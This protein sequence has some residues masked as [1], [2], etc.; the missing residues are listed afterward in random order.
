MKNINYKLFIILVLLFLY[1]ER[2]AFS[3]TR[4][5][6]NNVKEVRFLHK[7]LDS[8]I[9]YDQSLFPHKNLIDTLSKTALSIGDHHLLMQSLYYKACIS[10]DNNVK[11]VLLD[12]AMKMAKRNHES[13]WENRIA[14]SVSGVLRK[15]G[16]LLKAYQSAQ[17][18]E[19]FFRKEDMDFYQAIAFVQIGSVLNEIQD[20]KSAQSYFEKASALFQSCGNKVCETKNRLNIAV[21]LFRNGEK[22]KAYRTM[23]DLSQSSVCTAD[24]LFYLNVLV[25]IFKASDF[26][27]KWSMDSAMNICKRT[28]YPEAKILVLCC[29]GNAF[30]ERNSIDSAHMFYMEALEVTRKKNINASYT[31]P[32][33]LAL[34][35]I[36]NRKSLSDSAYEYLKRYNTIKESTLDQRKITHYQKEEMRK[37]ILQ[38]QKETDF[39][40]KKSKT[41]ITVILFFSSMVAVSGIYSYRLWQS[42]NK[43]NIKIKEELENKNRQLTTNSLLSAE[44]NNALRNIIERAEEMT[45]NQPIRIQTSKLMQDLKKMVHSGKEWDFFK[46]HFE[47]VHPNF[48]SLLKKRYPLLSENEL[49]I[50]ALIRIGLTNKEI[51]KMLNITSNTVFTFRYRI[52]KKFNDIGTRSLEDF[53]RDIN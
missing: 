41:T 51:A 46:G 14:L 6:H 53:L 26:K 15:N 39:Q 7:F 45:E 23:L 19:S 3:Q 37:A 29:M 52:K 8:L 5:V 44:R 28:H 38:A 20:Y 48:F 32:I 36:Y 33:Y 16:E 24:S 9:Y 31:L 27:A 40:R 1:T 34:S 2:T 30:L 49:R 4:Q 50:C 11:S 13:F 21:T 47:S 17:K 35:E 43:E 18:A 42:K 10:D 25:S 22:E 12:S